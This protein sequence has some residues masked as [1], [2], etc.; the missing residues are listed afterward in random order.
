M[1]LAMIGL[2][3]MGINLVENLLRNEN[4]VVAFDLNDDAKKAAA[5]L[6]AKTVDSLEEAVIA[7]K[8]PRIIWV[9]LPAGKPTNETI[10]K[11]S[12]LL[13]SDDIVID[14]GNSF[15][16]DSLKHN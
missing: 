13:D 9:M 2:G 7:L 16:E 6:G 14:G 15:Y 10:N 5:K 8:K 4:H 12:Q 3:K 11:L 1:D